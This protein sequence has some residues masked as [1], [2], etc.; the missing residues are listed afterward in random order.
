MSCCFD[1]AA[2]TTRLTRFPLLAAPRFPL[3]AGVVR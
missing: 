3:H 1:I 2:N